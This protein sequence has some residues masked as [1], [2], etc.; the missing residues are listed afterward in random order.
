M[1]RVTIL[2]LGR[3]LPY[4]LRIRELDP[5]CGEYYSGFSL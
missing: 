1:L 2:A 3:E 5:G 4:D